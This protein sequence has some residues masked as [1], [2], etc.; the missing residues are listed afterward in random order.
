MKIDITSLLKE[1][2][3]K[4]NFEFTESGKVFE[5]DVPIT[6]PLDIKVSLAN[7]GVGIM[8]VGTVSF[9]VKLMCSTCLK[10][11][12]KQFSLDFEER[13]VSENPNQDD[14]DL[15]TEYEM[16]SDDLYYAYSEDYEINLYDMI[17]DLIILNLPIAPKCDINCRVKNFNQSKSIDPRLKILEQFK[18]GG[19]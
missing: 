8:A 1:I 10:E 16:T 19:S 12:E 5:E 11:Y 13:F 17:R 9:T 15:L 2:G 3:L 7:A 18:N 4:A 6:S 14:K